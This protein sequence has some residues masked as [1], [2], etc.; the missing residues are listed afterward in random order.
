MTPPK[1]NAAGS[2]RLKVAYKTPESLLGEY[3]RSVG[4]GGVALETARAVPLGTRFVFELHASGVEQAVEVVGE[5][6]QV[7]PRQNGRF[8]LNVRYDAG[9]DEAGL[10]AVL[11]RIFDTHAYEKMRKH[12]RIPLHFRATEA[13]PNSPAF[14]V[15]DL[16]RG[17]VGIEVEAPALPAGVRVG[18]PFL[19]E[20]NL[21][22]GTLQLF[23]EVVWTTSAGTPPGVSPGFGVQFGRLRPETVERLEKLLSLATLP[24]APWR[25]RV[26]FGMDAVGRMP[27]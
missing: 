7:T 18:Q 11:Q 12:P 14:L 15:R 26:S 4:L 24:P 23:G 9:S 6:V 17:G 2:V 5:V 20:V 13:A 19:L 27:G 16:S 3:T 22:L 8:L 25:A 10:K 1:D 21:S